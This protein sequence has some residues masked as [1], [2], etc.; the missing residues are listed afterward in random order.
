MYA[1]YC[2]VNSVEVVTYYRVASAKPAENP[3]RVGLIAD[4]NPTNDDRVGCCR[5]QERVDPIR[6]PQAGRTSALELRREW[7]DKDTLT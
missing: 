4:R 6:E 2:R 7:F 3:L 1:L 5:N